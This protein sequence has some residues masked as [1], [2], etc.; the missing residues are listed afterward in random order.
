MVNVS[1]LIS[2]IEICTFNFP[3]PY[4]CACLSSAAFLLRDRTEVPP[5]MLPLTE[6][7]DR[8]YNVLK[9]SELDYVAVM[10][11]HIGGL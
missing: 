1:L 4:L 3:P 7:H 10:P 2:L 11:P 9:T 8:M 6:D 5:R